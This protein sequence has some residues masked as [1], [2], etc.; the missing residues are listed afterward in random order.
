MGEDLLLPG[1][2]CLRLSPA[3]QAFQQPIAGGFG[4]V[5]GG[6]R[7]QSPGTG[8]GLGGRRGAAGAPPAAARQ[9][10]EPAGNAGTQHPL[11]P[12]RVLLEGRLRPHS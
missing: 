4:Q 5:A 7:Q 3:A 2:F 9:G 10:E 1:A 6:G 11:Q 12:L 8:G